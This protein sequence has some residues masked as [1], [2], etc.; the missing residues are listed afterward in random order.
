LHVTVCYQLLSYTLD[1][2]ARAFLIA[3]YIVEAPH[4]TTTEINGEVSWFFDGV[5]RVKLGDQ[6]NGYDAEAVVAYGS[7]SSG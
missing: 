3:V 4:F 5:W 7:I 1:T 6:E 2:R